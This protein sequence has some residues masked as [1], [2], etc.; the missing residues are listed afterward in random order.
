MTDLHV[1]MKWV[2]DGGLCEEKRLKCGK[3]VREGRERGGRVG[4]IEAVD[5]ERSG[6]DESREVEIEKEEE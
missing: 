1:V 4:T 2:K 6:K 5:G 3:R